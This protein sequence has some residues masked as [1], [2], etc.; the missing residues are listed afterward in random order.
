MLVHATRRTE[1]PMQRSDTQTISI[2]APRQTVLDLVADPRELPRWAPDFARAIRADGEDWIVDTGD[3]ELRIRV[4][5][6]REHG[7]VDFLAAGLPAGVE[8]GAFSRVV[9]NGSGS[10]YAFTQFFADGTPDAD[11]ARQKAVVGDELRTL[12]ALCEAARTPV[13]VPDGDRRP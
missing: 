8:V 4:R 11:V 6:S 7:T 2:D 13:A 1:S 3:G 12:L 10:E 9:A 5:V